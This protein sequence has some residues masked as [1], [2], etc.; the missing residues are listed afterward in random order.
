MFYAVEVAQ[1]LRVS[2]R[3]VLNWINEGIIKAESIFGIW[4]VPG[5]ELKR[6]IL[7]TQP[8]SEGLVYRAF[9]YPWLGYLIYLM[10]EN[11]EDQTA[12]CSEAAR[13]HLL[14]PSDKDMVALWQSLK[15]SAPARIRNRME[16]PKATM[17]TLEAEDFKGWVADLGILGLYQN[18]YYPCADLLEDNSEIRL[19]TEV[20]FCGRVTYSEIIDILFRKYSFRITEEALQFFGTYFFNTLPFSMEDTETYLAR[21]SGQE[22]FLKRQAWGNPEA[23]KVAMD[24]PAEADFLTMFHK[25]AILAGINAES[26]IARGPSGIEMASKSCDMA[27]KAHERIL[28]EEK[29]RREREET[30]KAEATKS[31]EGAGSTGFETHPDE[32]KDFEELEQTPL[33]E[34]GEEDPEVDER[35][36]EAS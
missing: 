35:Q 19:T 31:A 14:T 21:L 27:V 24:L 11:K 23:A 13:Y 8:K 6:F 29:A 2:K 28:K 10:I 22:A 34:Q 32:P 12:I 15:R 17:P 33:G 3:T 1:I 16:S 30:A 4:R 18:A 26:Y 7:R 36:A 25:M 9:K 20:L 5:V